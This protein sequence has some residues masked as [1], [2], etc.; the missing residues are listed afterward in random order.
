M[1]GTTQSLFTILES[2]SSGWRSKENEFPLSGGSSLVSK[3][4]PIIE[5]GGDGSSRW[6][7]DVF[8]LIKGFTE[9][10]CFDRR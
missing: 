5:G 10:N 6:F 1:L 2:F 7:S 4:R 9:A 8:K 3:F